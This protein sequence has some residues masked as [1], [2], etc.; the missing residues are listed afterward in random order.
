MFKRIL[1]LGFLIICY[2]KANAFFFFFPLPNVSM[3]PVLQKQI[4]ALE[5]SSDTKAVA[6]TSEDKSF[7][8]KQWVFGQA[9]GQM[10]QEEANAKALR[11]C[12]NAL[13]RE[14]QKSIGGQSIYDFGKKTCE[15]HKFNNITLNLPKPIEPVQMTEKEVPNEN[16]TAKKLKDLQNL[17]EQKLITQEEYDKKRKEIIDGI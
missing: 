15:L 11:D 14:K 16:P 3:P 7:G 6:Y 9:A 10:T 1:F 2:T 13:N 8:S 17:L 5:K 4:D 12:E